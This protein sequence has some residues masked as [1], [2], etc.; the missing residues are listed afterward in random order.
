M[1]HTTAL[2]EGEKPTHREEPALLEHAVVVRV[3]TFLIAGVTG[4]GTKHLRE[5]LCSVLC[6]P[7][8]MPVAS[9]EEMRDRG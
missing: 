7:I 3:P 6:H 5:H 1:P 9:E 8:M 4:G 2:R